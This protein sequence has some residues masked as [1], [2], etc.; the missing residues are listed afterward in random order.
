M[1]HTKITGVVTSDVQDKTI[2][3]TVSSRL[4]HPLYRKQYTRNRKYIA[5]DEKNEAKK[6][7]TV[8]IIE[9]RPISRR[10][11]F[12]LLRIV[13]SGHGAVELKDEVAETVSQKKIVDEKPVKK[14]PKKTEAD[15]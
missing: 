9:T 7:D 3:I 6:G 10:K 12:T 1:S 2:V 8:E 5:H 4:T 11:S 14:S 13:E 15:V